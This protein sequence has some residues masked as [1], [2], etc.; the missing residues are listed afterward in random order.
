MKN[1]IDEERNDKDDDDRSWNGENMVVN[2]DP[3]Q[4]QNYEKDL[5]QNE[6]LP[7]VPEH[8]TAD[9]DFTNQIKRYPCL[10]CTQRFLTKELLAAH[11]LTHNSMDV[12]KRFSCSLCS[13]AFMKKRELDRHF[14]THT[15]MKPFKCTSCDK[16]FGRKDKLVRHMKI[17]EQGRSVL[18]TCPFC[19]SSFTRKDAF[20]Q[21]IKSHNQV[22][23]QPS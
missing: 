22:E 6:G 13:K 10:S 4:G 1:E 20:A 18:H 5:P 21:H 9:S 15:G 16:R 19:N 2:V 3:F 23:E 17:H 12:L 7:C 14:V 11:M 8:I